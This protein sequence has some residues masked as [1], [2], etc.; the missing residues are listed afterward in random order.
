MVATLKMWKERFCLVYFELMLYHLTAY[1]GRYDAEPWWYDENHGSSR[2]VCKWYVFYWQPRV[3]AF[4]NNP[5]IVSV[6]QGVQSIQLCW[7][8]EIFKKGFLFRT[9]VSLW[10]DRPSSNWNPVQNVGLPKHTGHQSAY[11]SQLSHALF[12]SLSSCTI[13]NNRIH[14]KYI[15]C[16][17][18]WIEHVQTHWHLSPNQPRPNIYARSHHPKPFH[19]N[20]CIPT[21]MSMMKKNRSTG[22]NIEG[23]NFEFCLFFSL[24][25]AWPSWAW[26]VI[27]ILRFLWK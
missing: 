15:Y 9:R 20:T 1:P 16:A 26:P 10:Y 13:E 3:P 7:T 8:T 5:I 14:I 18:D 2:A 23:T 6:T 27:T 12:R 19:P 17:T 24:R 25:L 21:D 22:G 11:G 4:F